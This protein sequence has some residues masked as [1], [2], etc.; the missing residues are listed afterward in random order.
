MDEGVRPDTSA[1]S[2]ARLRPAFRSTGTITAGNA[3]P[4][5]DGAAAVLM[6]DEQAAR[7]IGTAPVA[8]IAGRGMH[9]L[10]PQD[11]GLAPIRAA[12]VQSIACIDAWGVDPEIVNTKGG[13]IAIGHPLGA[14]GAR[15]IGTLCG[16]L[17]ESGER[18]GVAA[19]C[20]GVGQGLAMVLEN[21]A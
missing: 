20:I 8:R 1:D 3:S 10:E 17:Q 19:I 18:W 14:S 13:A 15:L 2:L 4:L 6:G 9:A 16:R 12:A 7:T 11:F 5:S 21:Q